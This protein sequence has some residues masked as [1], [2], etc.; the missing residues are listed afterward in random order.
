MKRMLLTVLA[1]ACLAAL[2]SSCAEIKAPERITYPGGWSTAPPANIPPADPNSLSDLRRENQQ[3]RDR[4]AWLE[5]HIRK[6]QNSQRKNDDEINKLH[7]EMDNLAAERD[8][9]RQ[10]AER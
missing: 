3:L 7:I 5:D 2:V 9:Y 8:R 6:L 4:T 1:A 10:A